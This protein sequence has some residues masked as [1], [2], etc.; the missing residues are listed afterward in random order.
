MVVIGLYP[1]M[2]LKE[3]RSLHTE[4]RK[5]V[6]DGHNPSFVF[7]KEKELEKENIEK[8]HLSIQEYLSAL[9]EVI[10]ETK[11]K[12]CEEKDKGNRIMANEYDC[13]V[14][15]LY[16]AYSLARRMLLPSP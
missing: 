15:G 12:V 2:Q 16:K 14:G 8:E 1:D 11:D 4:A 5:Y 10:I 7:R 13:E 3:A 6:E 9:E